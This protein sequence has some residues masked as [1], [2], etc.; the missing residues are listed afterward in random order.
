MSV[1]IHIEGCSPQRLDLP[2]FSKSDIRERDNIVK[3]LVS[4]AYHL[5]HVYGG[6]TIG[7][8]GLSS[9]DA[10]AVIQNMK[11]EMN[12]NGVYTALKQVVTGGK[13]VEIRTL[14]ILERTANSLGHW[15]NNKMRHLKHFKTDYKG[16]YL[17]LDLGLEK[18]KTYIAL[19][20][21]ALYKGM[22]PSCIDRNMALSTDVSSENIGRAIQEAVK[23]TVEIGSRSIP[24]E[25][26]T[27]AT[28]TLVTS[29][30]C[31][32]KMLPEAKWVLEALNHQW[33]CPVW[34]HSDRE[35]Q[36]FAAG[37]F[38]K[39][40]D[41][42]SASLGNSFSVGVLLDGLPLS[43]PSGC[44]YFW[45]DRTLDCYKGSSLAYLSAGAELAYASR[46]NI[47]GALGALDIPEINQAAAAKKHKYHLRAVEV[48]RYLAKHVA[49]NLMEL[50]L[51]CPFT[52]AIITGARSC[53]VGDQL[54]SEISTIIQRK[55]KSSFDVKF[56]GNKMN[57]VLTGA[58]GASLLASAHKQGIDVCGM[59]HS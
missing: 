27:L 57:P 35:A 15:A 26:A 19:D 34:F 54:V 51:I 44:E 53:Q 40:W 10:D 48:I 4:R 41:I 14:S 42:C 25:T 2:S 56:A 18:I 31:Q 36:S 37:V 29:R 12:R 1:N 16:L 11:N 28:I 3:T 30:A 55:Y 58:Y 59:K 50:N 46:Q 9:R 24:T 45:E 13:E 49:W 6:N 43:G 5:L 52:L 17:G 21:K 39:H 7:L 33:K 20:G 32:Q 23:K 8:S 38:Y 47:T 22:F